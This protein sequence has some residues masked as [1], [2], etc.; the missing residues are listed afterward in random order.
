MRFLAEKMGKSLTISPE[1]NPCTCY[2]VM[3]HD[4]QQC[5]ILTSI[6]SDEPVQ[7]P[8]KLRNSQMLF[9]Q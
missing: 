4:F 5:G 9:G 7:P 2:Q 6:D 8:L 1:N 3:T